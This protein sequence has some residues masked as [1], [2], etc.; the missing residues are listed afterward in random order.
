MAG[1]LWTRQ[2]MEE[3]VTSGMEWDR[4]PGGQERGT[5]TARK[6]TICQEK[7]QCSALESSPLDPSSLSAS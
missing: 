3:Q 2:E 1:G 4:E 6:D 7:T 5:R